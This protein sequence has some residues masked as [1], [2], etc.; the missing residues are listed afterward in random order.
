[1]PI[2]IGLNFINVLVELGGLVFYIYGLDID[3][4]T[5]PEFGQLPAIAGFFDT[6][7]GKARVRFDKIIDETTAGLQIF[8]GNPFGP[9]NVA[10]KNRSAET[11]YGIIGNGDGLFFI[12]GLKEHRHRAEEFFV[13]SWHARPDI[14]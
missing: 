13:V 10:R 8:G 11:K 9:F 12:P 6:T 5:D 2:R 3:E 7:E 1:M 4:F 14:G